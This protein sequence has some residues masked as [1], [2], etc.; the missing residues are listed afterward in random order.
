MTCGSAPGKHSLCYDWAWHRCMQPLWHGKHAVRSTNDI[1][2]QLLYGHALLSYTPCAASCTLGNLH[3]EQP[4][5][6]PEAQLSH[7]QGRHEDHHMPLL[8]A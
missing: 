2:W 6:L 4:S 7:Q 8:W 3:L 5:T 1:R